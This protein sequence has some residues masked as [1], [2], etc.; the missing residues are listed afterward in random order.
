MPEQS[1][2][3][4]DAFLGQ[5]L[6]FP[7][8]VSVQ[9]GLQLNATYRNIED[10]IGIIL[11]TSLGERIY[12]P[13]FGSRLSELVFAP[14]NTQTLLLIRLYVE[15]ALKKWEPRIVLDGVLT[16]PDP[17]NGRVDITI[18]YHPKGHHDSRS[19]VYP[20]YLLPPGEV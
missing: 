17:L 19:L 2:Q 9:G 1:S 7:L 14:L 4:P 18:E 12:R 8:Q 13:D 20:F 5:G 15:E 11:R 10:S 6:S 16:E 3:L